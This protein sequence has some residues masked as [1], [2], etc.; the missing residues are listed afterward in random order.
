MWTYD[1]TDPLMVNLETIMSLAS[2]MYVADLD[3]FECHLGDKKLSLMI[4]FGEC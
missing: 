4:L 2:M 1:L 3:A